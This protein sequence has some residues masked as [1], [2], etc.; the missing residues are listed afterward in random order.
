MMIS[1]STPST[2]PTARA[3]RNG[4]D[5]KMRFYDAFL[6]H[7]DAQTAAGRNV[8]ICGDVNTAHKA[9][10]L[11]RPKPNEKISG[12]LPM[13]REWIDKLLAHRLP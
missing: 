2:S 12:F 9:I 5:Y 13:E 6:E 4:L 7:V 8:V 11:A 3:P 10:D 1:S